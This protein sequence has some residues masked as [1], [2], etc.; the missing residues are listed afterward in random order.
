MP[1]D[2][3]EEFRTYVVQFMSEYGLQVNWFANRVQILPR[4]FSSF[5][6]GKRNFSKSK[7][8][9]IYNKIKEYCDRISGF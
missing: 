9:E 3:Q 7:R 1:Y 6:N 5:L 8:I 2:D 4:D